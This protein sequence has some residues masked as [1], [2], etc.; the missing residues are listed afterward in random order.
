ML[1]G[2]VFGTSASKL[3]T[4]LI[5]SPLTVP[6]ETHLVF[7]KPT[8]IHLLQPVEYPPRA[9]IEAWRS[10]QGRSAQPSTRRCNTCWAIEEYPPAPALHLV[11][12]PFLFVFVVL[13]DIHQ[14]EQR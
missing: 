2:G 6:S 9:G 8:P 10:S 1:H 13:A 12:L 7:Q 4:V 14:T 3:I 5:S 11:S